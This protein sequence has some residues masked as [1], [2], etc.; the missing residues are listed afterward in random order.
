M[1][2]RVRTIAG[3]GVMSAL[4][5]LYF[6]FVGIR[7]IAL[8]QSETVVAKLMG[9]ALL[10]LPLI[11]FWA[12][13]RELMFGYRATQLVDILDAEGQLPD[14]LGEPSGN[15]RPDRAQA[16]A[17]FAHYQREANDHPDSWRAFARLSIVYDAAR[18][19]TRARAA[20]REAISL[21][22]NEKRNNNA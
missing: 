10:V 20:I 16:D 4:L 11:G 2:R 15:G 21:F 9:T 12:L 22:R 19:R 7:S 18:D 8:L 14:D 1:N 17:V 6:A 13:I 5:V 3:V